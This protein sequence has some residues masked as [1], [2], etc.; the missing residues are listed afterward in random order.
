[1][2]LPIGTTSRD[3]RRRH[4]PLGRPTRS[5]RRR[6]LNEAQTA[7]VENVGVLV[8]SGLIAGEALAGL[9]TG[10]FN[11]KYGKLPEVFEHPSYLVGRGGD[12]GARADADPDPAGERRR[13]ERACAAGGDHVDM[14][15]ADTSPE[16]W[17][18]FLDLHRRIA[19]SEKVRRAYELSEMLRRM[20]AEG[21]R[22]RHPDADDQEIF[23]RVTRQRLGPEL[24]RRAYGDVL[25]D[26]RQ[27]VSYAAR[28]A[29]QTEH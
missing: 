8:A 1:M 21:L 22:R 13:S 5:A 16:A 25:P 18:V 23:L 4:D 29:P 19:P 27:R 2:Y 26:E 20:N 3:F 28:H 14:R 12:G 11:Y 9:V 7:R 15:P 24:F 17:K 10:W 6:A